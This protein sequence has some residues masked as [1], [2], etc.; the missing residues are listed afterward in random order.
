MEHLLE[1]T[2][3]S[4]DF[5]GRDGTVRAVDEVSFVIRGG[6]RLGL[7]GESGAGKSVVARALLGLTKKPGPSRPGP[8]CSTAATSCG[9]PIA[10]STACAAGASR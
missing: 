1:V 5:S 6:E 9:C 10:S 7:V 8:W 2:D 4:I 3:L